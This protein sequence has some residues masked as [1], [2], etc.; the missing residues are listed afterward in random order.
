MSAFCVYYERMCACVR[1]LRS[2]GSAAASAFE[3]IFIGNE[4]DYRI[5]RGGSMAMGSGLGALPH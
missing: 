2:V 5:V 3:L 4:L 1:E